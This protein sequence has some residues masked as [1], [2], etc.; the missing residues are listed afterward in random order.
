MFTSPEQFANATKT[1]FDLQMQT[2][3]ALA[4]KTVKGVEQVVALNLNA[5][6][7]SVDSTMA[8]GRSMAEATQ[9]GNT[10]AAFDTLAARMQPA[11]GVTNATEYATQLKSIIDEMHD[12]FRGA[13]DAHVAEAKNTLSALIYDVTQNVKPGSENA[14]EIIKAAIENAFK[15]YEQVTQ[16]TRQA[17]QTVEAQFER[18]SSIVTPGA[19][20]A[21][22]SE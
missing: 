6:K 14:V 12:E 22:K 2:F 21:Q 10:K 18:A 11:A 17:V 8:A 15:G 9:A 20:K 7:S 1:L 5:A 19:G 16:A 3:N 13:A 4:G